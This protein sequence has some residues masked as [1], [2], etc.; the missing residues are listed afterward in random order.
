MPEI[1]FGEGVND[2]VEKENFG[3]KRRIFEGNFEVS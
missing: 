3:K 2:I 1:T